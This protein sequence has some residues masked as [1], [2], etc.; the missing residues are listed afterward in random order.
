MKHWIWSLLPMVLT[1]C[2]AGED[3]KERWEMEDGTVVYV[4]PAVREYASE[5]QFADAL[6]AVDEWQPGFRGRR[7]TIVAVRNDS[8]YGVREVRH[9]EWEKARFGPWAE[10]YG[11]EPGRTYFVCSAVAMKLL[12]AKGDSFPALDGS[13]YAGSNADSI[14]FVVADGLLRGYSVASPQWGGAFEVC[15]LLRY[16]GYDASLRAV[17]D[18]Y[19]VRRLDDLKWCYVLV[20]MDEPAE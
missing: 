8:V 5:D 14:G 10:R 6:L 20:T 3:E 16:V 2:G 9:V 15:T 7:G 19:P 12:P 11:W 17:G 18:Y 13:S 4:E 1:A